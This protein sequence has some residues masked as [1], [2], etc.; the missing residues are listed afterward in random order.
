MG[1]EHLCFSCYNKMMEA[2]LGVKLETKMETFSLKDGA[3]NERH[4]SVNERLDPIGIFMEAVENKDNGYQFA[5][6]GELDGDQKELYKRLVEKVQ[7]GIQRFH[8]EEGRFP[9]GQKYQTIAH[10]EVIGRLDYDPY[11]E[12][13]PLVII[14]GKPYTW[15]QLG[16]MVM[17]F[18]GFQIRV[19][20]VD[21]TDN[22]E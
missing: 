11:N 22:V 12:S 20:M 5:V 17:S 8:I 18:E 10:N 13:T 7:K 15:E 16:E 9:N 3:G 4:F 6:H 14:D 19:K 1:A 2:E 21:M